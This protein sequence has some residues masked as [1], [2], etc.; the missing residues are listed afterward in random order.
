MKCLWKLI[1][2]FKKTIDINAVKRL[3]NLPFR[4]NKEKVG[5]LL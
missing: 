5:N 4:D 2:E 1:K 3:H